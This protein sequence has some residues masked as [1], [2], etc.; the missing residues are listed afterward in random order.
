MSDDITDVTVIESLPA[1]PR[2][3]LPPE[4]RKALQEYEVKVLADDPRR[5]LAPSTAGKFFSLFLQGYGSKEIHDLNPSF[6]LGMIV[7]ARVKYGWDL[8]RENHLKELMGRVKEKVLLTQLESA[9]YL[10]DVLAAIHKLN[11]DKIKKFLQTGDPAEL[12]DLSIGTL[13]NYAKT[14]E[15]ISKLTGQ[16]REKVPAPISIT[17]P[18]PSSISTSLGES[19][20]APS[21]APSLSSTDAAVLLKGLLDLEKE[22]TKK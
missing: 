1:D 8:E 7:H 5:I 6:P 13:Q 21:M 2:D 22:R 9:H 15:L 10:T 16:N 18:V 17:I 12:K 4:E 3:L 14:F 11:G 19:P 20:V